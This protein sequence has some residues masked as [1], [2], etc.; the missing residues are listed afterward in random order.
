[1]LLIHLGSRIAECWQ[2]GNF[3]ARHML[4]ISGPFAEIIRITEFTDV[5]AI[6]KPFVTVFEHAPSYVEVKDSTGVYRQDVVKSGAGVDSSE[7][8]RHQTLTCPIAP[9]LQ[10]V[11]MV[12]SHENIVRGADSMIKPVN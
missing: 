1:M 5:K 7:P 11:V 12:P 4:K 3:N 9:V 6:S 10:T 2:A 8:V